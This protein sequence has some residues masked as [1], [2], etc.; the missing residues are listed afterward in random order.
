MW[1]ALALR[2]GSVACESDEALVAA[3]RE[4][5]DAFGELYERYLPGVYRYLRAR[6]ASGDEAADLTQLVFLRVLRAL[7]RYRAG[8]VPFASWLF[9][10]ARNAATDAHRRRKP[11]VSWDYVPELSTPDDHDGPEALALRQE[12]LTHLRALLARLDPSKRELL[13]FRFAAGLSAREIAPIVGKSEAAV[14]KQLTRI[15]A[16]L[17]EYYRD[18]LS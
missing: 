12:R 4:R 10:I 3:A 9:R 8:R 2:A 14:K 13:A 5:S 16:T 18:E 6:T 17:K 1:Q 11:A 7:P 15:I